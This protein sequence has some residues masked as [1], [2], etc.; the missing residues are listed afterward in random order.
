MTPITDWLLDDI[1][2]RIKEASMFTSTAEYQVWRLKELGMKK[3]RINKE[4]RRRLKMTQKQ[5]DDLITESAKA[6]YLQY[7]RFETGE[8]ISETL[9][10]SEVQ[11]M[12]DNLYGKDI[13]HGEK[14]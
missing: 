13:L 11:Q 8:N 14:S 1:V 4:L 12:L 3:G 5:I 6:G 2:R 10:K 9:T 7:A